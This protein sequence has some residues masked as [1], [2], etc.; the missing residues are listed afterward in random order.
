MGESCQGGRPGGRL[1]LA[2]EPAD[3]VGREPLELL[4]VV[5]A[6]GQDHVL[7]ARR[8]ES[9][10]PLDDLSRRPEEVRLL[11]ILERPMRAHHALEDRALAAVAP[12]RGRSCRPGAGSSGDRTAANSGR[13]RSWRNA[14]GWRG[15]RP[16]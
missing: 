3:D 14:R 8:L 9:P 15:R 1:G 2:L 12:A 6:G 5:V 10:D 16:W 11:E 7:D 4:E 13:V